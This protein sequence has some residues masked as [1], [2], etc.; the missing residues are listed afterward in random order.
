VRDDYRFVG[1]ETRFRV[2]CWCNSNKILLTEN[3]IDKLSKMNLKTTKNIPSIYRN[4]K[5]ETIPEQ[6]G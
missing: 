6:D 3:E 2:I 4:I 5:E 1:G